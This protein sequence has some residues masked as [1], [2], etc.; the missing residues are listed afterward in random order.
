MQE[1]GEH[2]YQINASLEELITVIPNDGI[3]Y[4]D[5]LSCINNSI[6]KLNKCE[7]PLDM[8]QLARVFCDF[9]EKQIVSANA[10]VNVNEPS[11]KWYSFI[12][13]SGTTMDDCE[14]SLPELKI[15]GGTTYI[16]LRPRQYALLRGTHHKEIERWFHSC[17]KGENNLYIDGGVAFL[18][19]KSVKQCEHR[20]NEIQLELFVD[21]RFSYCFYFG[22]WV[23]DAAK[24]HLPCIKGSE[25]CVLECI[26]CDGCH[27]RLACTVHKE[28]LQN[29]KCSDAKCNTKCVKIRNIIQNN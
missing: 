21:I 9:F 18:N 10:S 25:K 29:T 17:P 5:V 12:I 13:V 6:C 4:S 1:L 8:N 26:Y 2:L 7:E 28:Y 3:D 14:D 15:D 11:K 24:Q 23:C 20:S 16:F 19:F 22:M 27:G